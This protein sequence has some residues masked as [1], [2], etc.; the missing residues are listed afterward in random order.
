MDVDAD[1]A[2]QVSLMMLVM[3]LIMF[4]I[5]NQ[6]VQQSFLTIVTIWQLSGVNER[7]NNIIGRVDA[8]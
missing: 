7:G 8:Y 2:L 1:V 3:L 5:F 6:K 4:F